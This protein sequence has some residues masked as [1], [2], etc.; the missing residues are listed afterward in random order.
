MK[1]NDLSKNIYVL[2]LK[3]RLDR[4]KHI[5]SQLSKI[6]CGDYSLIES[7]DGDSLINPTR[8]KN[9]MY[10]LIKTYLKIYE[11]LSKKNYEDVLIVEDDCIFCEDFN[12]LLE[13]YISNVPDDWDFLY[14]GA[15]HNYHMGN[16]TQKINEEVIKLNNSYSAHCVLFKKKV[17][18]DLILNIMNFSIENDVMMANLQKKYNAYSSSVTLTT[19]LA[20]FS[21]IE[22]KLSDYGWLI[23]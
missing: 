12:L 8:L 20:N 23:K 18:D 5:E 9:G 21:N 2:N 11:D 6:N 13:K 7:V 15:N 10:G 1:I 14:F 3:K 22:N 19:Q 17:F 16:V 4:K